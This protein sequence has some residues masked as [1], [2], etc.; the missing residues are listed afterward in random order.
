MRQTVWEEQF[1][2]GFQLVSQI[3]QNLSPTVCASLFSRL[4]DWL[5][6]MKVRLQP[7]NIMWSIQEISGTLPL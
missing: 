7:G 6:I 5:E 3:R 2:W 1:K 4:N